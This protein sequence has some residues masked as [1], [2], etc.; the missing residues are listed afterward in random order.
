MPLFGIDRVFAHLAMSGAV[1]ME[2]EYGTRRAVDAFVAAT[3]LV[4]VVAE[5]KHVVVVV[6]PSSVTV[7]IEVA[8]SYKTVRFFLTCGI[9]DCSLRKLEQENT[10]RSISETSSSSA[11]D[12]LV[13]P[14]GLLLS[15]SQTENW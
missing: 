12:V 13:L 11:G 7:G 2:G 4:D 8:I 3:I 14:I 6:L 10:A 5:V 1:V 15:E 9:C